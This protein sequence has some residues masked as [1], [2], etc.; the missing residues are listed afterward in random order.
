MENAILHGIMEKE[1]L[2]G[3]ITI[4]G[5]MDGSNIRLVVEDD[6]VGMDEETVRGIMNSSLQR[7]SGGYKMR[8]IHHPLEIMFGIPYGLTVESTVGR[9]TRVTLR[10][11]QR[12]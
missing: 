5:Y 9:G 8:N 6:G 10:L 11:P 4:C 12:K 1:N 3:T 2:L 7:E